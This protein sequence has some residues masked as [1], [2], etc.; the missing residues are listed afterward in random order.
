MHRNTKEGDVAPTPLV[1]WEQ[2]RTVHRGPGARAPP[3][4]YVGGTVGKGGTAIGVPANAYTLYIYFTNGNSSVTVDLFWKSLKF[5]K[6]I[7]DFIKISHNFR[8]FSKNIFKFNQIN[9]KTFQHFL[10]IFSKITLTRLLYI[11]CKNTLVL[12]IKN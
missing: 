1:D 3:R 8:V 10:I 5:I 9:V 6:K 2:V 12:L 11:L 7:L 4:P